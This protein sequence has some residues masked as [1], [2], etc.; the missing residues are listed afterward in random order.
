MSGGVVYVGTGRAYADGLGL[1][2]LRFGEPINIASGDPIPP[3]WYFVNAAWQI[4]V[5]ATDY[6]M[7]PGFCISDGRAEA[8]AAMVAIPV[9]AKPPGDWPWPPPW[10]LT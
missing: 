1:Q 6:P 8:T 3:G 9:G 7:P 4:T 2:L 5:G 10:P